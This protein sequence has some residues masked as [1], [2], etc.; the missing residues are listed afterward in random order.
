MPTHPRQAIRHA[1]VA[2]LLGQT[3]A[4]SRVYPDRRVP[5]QRVELPALAVYVPTESVELQSRATAPREL[6]RRAQVVVEALVQQAESV[7]DALD[8]IALEVENALHRD[9]T[10][11]GVASDLL[12][13]S[14]ETDVVD[15]GKQ[16]IGVV[17][18][19]FEVRYYSEAVPAATLDDFKT[20]DVRHGTLARDTVEVQP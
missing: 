14:T 3:A 10:L 9:W 1:V 19:E 15:T 12:L 2:Q 13:T 17:R 6:D 16:L 7:D 20:A 18:L 4:G 5:F 8:A 11:G